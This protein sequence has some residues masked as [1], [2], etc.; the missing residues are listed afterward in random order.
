MASKSDFDPRL[1]Y[2]PDEDHWHDAGKL[3]TEGAGGCKPG[4]KM[5]NG[6]CKPA[7]FAPPNPINA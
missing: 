6:K 2:T 3:P 5:V 1:P 4:F 7:E